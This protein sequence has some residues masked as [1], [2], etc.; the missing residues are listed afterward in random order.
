MKQIIKRSILL[1]VLTLVIFGL[2]FAVGTKKTLPINSG[3]LE[4]HVSFTAVDASIDT[5]VY[6]VEP[7]V[8]TLTF[9]IY[10][11]DSASFDRVSL[12]RICTVAGGTTAAVVL[13]TVDTLSGWTALNVNAV[14]QGSASVLQQAVTLSPVPDQ[15][16]FIVDRA[17]ANTGVTSTTAYYGVRKTYYK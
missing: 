3:A 14:A 12:R 7:G 2:T 5:V 9:F 11:P 15:I 6:R 4:S 8:A 13:T 10:N 16:W 1:A 17:A